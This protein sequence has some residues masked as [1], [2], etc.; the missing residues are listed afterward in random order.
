SPPAKPAA[1]TAPSPAPTVEIQTLTIEKALG[2]FVDYTTTPPYA[3][4]LEDLD[5]TFSPLTTTPG[6]STRFAATGTLGGGSFKLEGEEAFGDRPTSEVKLEI[7]DF[8]VPRAN[9]YLQRHTAWTA[10][11]GKLDIVGTYKL[12]GS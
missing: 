6:R 12:D 8:V 5:A 10:S 9:A 11:S 1:S 7:R 3:E 2:R 4:E